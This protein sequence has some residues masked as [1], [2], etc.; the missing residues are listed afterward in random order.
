MGKKPH[1]NKNPTNTWLGRTK[2]SLGR[3]GSKVVEEIEK[4][5][6]KP[7]PAPKSQPHFFSVRRENGEGDKGAAC[8][9][10]TPDFLNGIQSSG[11]RAVSRSRSQLRLCKRKII[12]IK[13][14][15]GIHI[16]VVNTC[17]GVCPGRRRLRQWGRGLGKGSDPLPHLPFQHACPRQNYS[18]SCR[19]R[20]NTPV[21]ALLRGL[22]NFWGS[23]PPFSPF[24]GRGASRVSGPR[25]PPPLAPSQPPPLETRCSRSPLRRGARACEWTARPA[26]RRVSGTPKR[27]ASSP[28]P[29][30]PDGGATAHVS[31]LAQS[32]PSLGLPELE[33][34]E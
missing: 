30:R 34:P 4:P 28:L 24:P 20:S 25:S 26:L 5:S 11:S 3:V 18:P 15:Q 14:I 12:T 22:H 16:G 29:H 32:G 27:A 21:S 31:P 1:K 8:C 6:W 2:R 13:K 19:V 17:C 10:S 23:T 7:S 9:L 33:D